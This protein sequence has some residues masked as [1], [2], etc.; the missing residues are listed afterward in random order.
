[1]TNQRFSLPATAHRVGGIQIGF[2]LSLAAFLAASQ[3]AAVAE[4]NPSGTWNVRGRDEAG[5]DWVAKLVLMPADPNEYPPTKF[6]GH[7]D[8][9]GS[10]R[11]S[12]RETIPGAVY[13]YKTRVLTMSGADLQNADPAL[14]TAQ[15]RIEMT[16]DASRLENGTWGG[17]SVVPGTWQ[18]RRPAEAEPPGPRRR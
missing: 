4:P 6:R 10:N 12:G 16:E 9:W 15:Y 11:V 14:T 1:M 18:A 17:P 8:W 5:I 3:T 7:F 2:A 13:D